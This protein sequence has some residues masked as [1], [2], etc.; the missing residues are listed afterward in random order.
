MRSFVHS[1]LF[2]SAFALS[3]LSACGG[4][5]GG[6]GGSNDVVDPLSAPEQIS[7]LEADESG[8]GSGASSGDSTAPGAGELPVDSDYNLDVTSVHVFDP[9]MKPLSLINMILCY[10]A[11]TAYAEKLNE[12]N[13]KAQT[14]IGLCE[15]GEDSGDQGG[16]SGASS[17]A[18]AAEFMLFTVN[19]SRET[20]E[21]DQ[22]VKF[23]V[24]EGEGGT[25][26][27][28]VA[29]S[30]GASEADPFGAFLMDYAGV[31]EG[32]TEADAQMF[33]AL[34]TIDQEGTSGFR[35]YEN[36][37]DIDQPHLDS[38]SFSKRTAV[39]LSTEPD[40]ESGLA[41][42]LD[43][44]R[45]HDFTGDT[46]ILTHEWKIAYDAGYFKRQLDDGE[47]VTFSRTQFQNS[48]W[49]YNLY[50]AGGEAAGSRVELESGFGF[51]TESGDYGWVGYYGLWVP[52]G[53]SVEDGDTIT[54]TTF[55]GGVGATYKVVRAP[56]KLIRHARE[57]LDLAELAGQT[58]NWWDNGR[59]TNFLLDYAAGFFNMIAY[60]DGGEWV[61]IDPPEVVDVRAQGGFL[62]MWSQTLGGSVSYLEGESV[63]TYYSQ[64][65]VNGSSP[66]F[67]GVLD[68]FVT[69]YGYIQCLDSE[70]TGAE[71]NAGDVYLPE[72]F[73]VGAPYSFRFDREDLTLY[74]DVNGHGVTLEQVGLAEG[75]K[76]THGPNIWGMSS[77]PLVLDTSGLSGVWDLWGQ[78]EF[79]TYETGH[80]TWNGYAAVVDAF[81][82]YVVFDAPL[83]FLY[84]HSQANDLNDD[85]TYDGQKYFLNYGGPGDLWGIPSEGTDFDDDGQEDRW[86]P[87]FSIRGGTLAGPTGT[88]YLVR[89]MEIEQSLLEDPA[90][91][92]GLDLSGAA[93]LVLPDASLYT[94]PGIG[95]MPVVEGP[96]VVVNGVVVGS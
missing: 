60:F 5:G 72:S 22:I 18:Q 82:D 53:V 61:A 84:T 16:D 30:E 33:G 3:G 12:G 49:R 37:G 2:C 71:A 8:L 75:E 40:S 28:R 35:L 34:G 46:G 94:A 73:E 80:N 78:E 10:V 38:R 88:E 11:H 93:A 87:L 17:G 90:G 20:S 96:P 42:I 89:P 6:G 21:S 48:A 57:T 62:Q 52:E 86:Y 91:S 54:E 64:E 15:S 55:D 83:Q 77:G 32:G 43:R 4:G 9:S 19:S 92:A 41:H 45:F 74:W 27:A 63:V 26:H 65:F 70:I 23:W 47:E 13:Y 59:A 31:P 67:D 58:F 36:E 95:E 25:I 1:A 29:I 51:Q 7:L 81:G 39:A 24:P 68:D 69:L 56:G 79:F 14:D 44:S 85:A 76:P 50:H 66:L